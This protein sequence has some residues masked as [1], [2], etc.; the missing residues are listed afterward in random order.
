[1]KHSVHLPGRR[2]CDGDEEHGEGVQ[3]VLVSGKVLFLSLGN[4]CMCIN[5]MKLC[6]CMVFCFCF[7]CKRLIKMCYLYFIY[8]ELQG[9]QTNFILIDKIIFKA[10]TF[11]SLCIQRPERCLEPLFPP[12]SWRDLLTNPFSFSPEFYFH[13]SSSS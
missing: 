5:F 6:L 8:R 11:T 4:S 9:M 13:C 10:N 12:L 3:I 7:I 2:D 1:M